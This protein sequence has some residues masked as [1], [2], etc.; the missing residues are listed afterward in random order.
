[1]RLLLALIP[2]WSLGAQSTP[3]LVS[4]S[5]RGVVLRWV[6]DEG[7]RPSGYLV[8]RRAVGGSWTR[9]TTLPVTRV[10][11]RNAARDRVGD[12]FDRYAGLL[13]PEDPRAEQSDPETFRGMLLL[14]ADLEPGVAQVL[15]L[16]YDDAAA[17]P[18]STYE[19]RLLA[20]TE[21]GERVVATSGAV[22]AGG[23]RPAPAPESLTAAA[24]TRGVALRWTQSP[25]FSAY[26]VYRGARRDG[27]DARRIND[28][29]V[30]VF[31]RDGSPLEVSTSFYTD[32]TAALDETVFYWV[33]GSDAFG[34]IS[35]RSLPAAF[36]ARPVIM[37][38][39]PMGIQSRVQGDTV[40]VTWRT[41]ADSAVTS[42]Q[43]WRAARDTGPFVKVGQPL[44]APA[45]ELRDAGRP[46]RRLWWYRVT[47]LDRAGR[48]S[49]PS[50]VALAEVPDLTPPAVPESLSA[51]ADTGKLS[52]RW[53]RSSASDLRGYRVYRSNAAG[54][55]FGL[56]SLQP[57]RAPAFTDAV[58][59]RADHP[60]YYR[61]TAVDSAFNESAPSAVVAV[62]PPDVTP[63]SAPRIAMVRPLDG[64]LAIA[65]LPNPEA[66]V[67]AYRV[68]VR[69]RGDAAWQEQSMATPAG[70]LADT[71]PGLAPG[72]AHEVTLVA[73]DDAG[74]RS[75]A[76]PVVLGTP[77][78]RRAPD[79]PELRRVAYERSAGGAVVEWTRAGAGASRVLVLR[80]EGAGPWRPVA[81]LAP[82]AA[83]FV[84]RTTRAGRRYEY[85]LQVR[86]AF[87]NASESKPRRVTLPE[88]SR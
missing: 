6:W 50:V 42:F 70:T 55:T 88:P 78:R 77:V 72:R 29:P 66:D 63:P 40:I 53:R 16:R 67:V 61:V 38:A 84:D 79:A 71:I 19:Y 83:R 45:Q 13:F 46:A 69:V 62:R 64:A 5:E 35:G 37:V 39:P 20:L 10:R 18:G 54:G 59:V 9:L 41:P 8:E 23:Y 81:E 25:R 15:G 43:V 22:V 73:V 65:W 36:V 28:A 76:A 30:V 14:A 74:N 26:H 44:R 80:R 58:P 17:T 34:R 7:P 21:S 82:T 85:R 52:L 33:A 1:M 11:D 56:L 48:E 31:T 68:R 4:P 32:T 12:Q 49:G 51:V 75:V 47:A 3:L 86:D 24:G 27:G 60:F 2:V 57:Q 87:G